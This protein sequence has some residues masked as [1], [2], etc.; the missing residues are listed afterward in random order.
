MTGGCLVR[1]FRGWVSWRRIIFE[2]DSRKRGARPRGR[3]SRRIPA[4][5]GRQ[6][7]K[8]QPSRRHR[9]AAVPNRPAPPNYHGLGIKATELQATPIVHRVIRRYW[10]VV[11]NPRYGRHRTK[12]TMLRRW[13]KGFLPYRAGGLP[14]RGSKGRRPLRVPTGKKAFSRRWKGPHFANCKIAFVVAHYL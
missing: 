4:E 7:R 8:Y 5:V 13:R 6:R 1:C 3:A 12:T 9:R 10:E 11:R 14:G 2:M